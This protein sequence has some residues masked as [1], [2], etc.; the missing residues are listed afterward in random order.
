MSNM[1]ALKQLEK[2]PFF[3]ADLSPVKEFLTKAIV[4]S[5]SNEN[6]LLQAQSNLKVIDSAQ[7]EYKGYMSPVAEMNKQRLEI[8]KVFKDASD[9]QKS[10]IERYIRAKIQIE[11]EIEQEVA[12]HAQLIIEEIKKRKKFDFEAMRNYAKTIKLSHAA[13]N[14]RLKEK[15]EIIIKSFQ[16]MS[17]AEYFAQF[18]ITE[19]VVTAESVVATKIDGI[20]PTVLVKIDFTELM[21]NPKEAFEF[22]RILTKDPVSK[23][24]LEE[25]AQILLK[26]EK[27]VI[28]GITYKD[29]I[30]VVLK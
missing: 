9:A 1:T 27:P 17:E 20:K 8:E 26:D 6:E 3:K 13:S 30:K 11:A 7:K 23:K 14:E 5:V 18:E 22:L 29:D 21:S 28:N 12:R 15:V 24:L 10:Q 4:L 16:G 25:R 19:A 2:N